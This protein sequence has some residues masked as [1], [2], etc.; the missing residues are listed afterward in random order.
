MTV[1]L[2]TDVLLTDIERVRPRDTR[3][4]GLVDGERK[5]FAQCNVATAWM[6]K[7]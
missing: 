2:T 7:T 1:I 5:T 3:F 6:P 4:T